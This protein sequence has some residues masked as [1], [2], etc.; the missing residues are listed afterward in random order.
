M[1][2]NRTTGPLTMVTAKNNTTSTPSETMMRVPCGDKADARTAVDV[3][4]AD[5]ADVDACAR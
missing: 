2:R 1:G 5:G 3:D 4:V